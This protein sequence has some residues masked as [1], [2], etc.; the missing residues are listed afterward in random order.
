M[1]GFYG[2]EVLLPTLP[3]DLQELWKCIRLPRPEDGSLFHE[4]P[5]DSSVGRGQAFQA[6]ARRH[7]HGGPRTRPPPHCIARGTM[8]A[9]VPHPWGTCQSPA[10]SLSSISKR[11]LALPLPTHAHTA[12][13]AHSAV[14]SRGVCPGNAKLILT[15]ILDKQTQGVS[16][17]F[18]SGRPRQLA[19][20]APAWTVP[21]FSVHM[22]R[23]RQHAPPWALNSRA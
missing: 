20:S 17:F 18:S 4:R 22:H 16:S 14:P 23:C 12:P 13:K 3:F 21:C 10:S 9:P 2:L 5:W 7:R 6:P 19:L 11:Q 15:L 8:A 1:G